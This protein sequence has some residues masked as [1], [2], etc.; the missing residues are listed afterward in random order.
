MAR[1]AIAVRPT[2]ASERARTRNIP[3]RGRPRDA[4]DQGT[5]APARRMAGDGP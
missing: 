5:D 2:L 3:A 4:C 1:N